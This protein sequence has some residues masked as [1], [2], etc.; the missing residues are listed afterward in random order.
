MANIA[1]VLNA[2]NRVDNKFAE[3][4]TAPAYQEYRTLEG[5]PAIR[6]T[7]GDGDI[8]NYYLD[9]SKIVAHDEW[10]YEIFPVYQEE[11]IPSDIKNKITLYEWGEEDGLTSNLASVS[12]FD[13]EVAKKTGLY[14]LNKT[15]ADRSIFVDDRGLKDFYDYEKVTFLIDYRHYNGKKI[16]MVMNVRNIKGSNYNSTLAKYTMRKLV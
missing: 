6:I 2:L 14:L 12:A 10:D 16:P 1:N 13:M 11:E 7:D 5:N 4:T 15:S 9:G 8:T 3:G